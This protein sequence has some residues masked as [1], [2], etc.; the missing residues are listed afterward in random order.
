MSGLGPR[1]SA[2][3]RW[4]WKSASWHS[5]RA[6][7][8]AR[9]G[10]WVLVR[11]PWRSA[12]GLTLPAAAFTPQCQFQLHFVSGTPWF[13]EKARFVPCTFSPLRVLLRLRLARATGH[14][15]PTP[16]PA[17]TSSECNVGCITEH[18]S[19][20]QWPMRTSFRRCQF[21]AVTNAQQSIHCVSFEADLR[22]FAGQFR[23]PPCSAFATLQPLLRPRWLRWPCAAR[24]PSE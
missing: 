2:V 24:H 18:P 11:W 7:C 5:P 15:W 13:S 22:R 14:G 19:D 10:G 23:A 6:R 3:A 4:L 21:F 8:L 1:E 17:R 12:S 9:W 16:R 20:G